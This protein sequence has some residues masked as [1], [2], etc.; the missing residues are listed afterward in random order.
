[1]K[2]FSNEDPGCTENEGDADRLV[3]EPFAAW[4]SAA[5]LHFGTVD[6]SKGEVFA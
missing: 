4:L 2:A 1:M 5:L 3:G 6:Q